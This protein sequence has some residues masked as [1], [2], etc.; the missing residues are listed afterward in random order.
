VLERLERHMTADQGDAE[1]CLHRN[2]SRRVAMRRGSLI[3]HSASTL[4]GKF[5]AVPCD[6]HAWLCV[7]SRG[8]RHGSRTRAGASA[9]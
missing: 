9:C 5:G 2:L 1:L 3:E 4:A 8:G 7:G 6:R